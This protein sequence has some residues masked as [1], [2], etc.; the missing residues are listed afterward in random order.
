[1]KKKAL[2]EKIQ[3][4]E[5]KVQTLSE[6]KGIDWGKWGAIVAV[7]LFILTCAFGYY[8]YDKQKK[9]AEVVRA[10]DNKQ[11]EAERVEK[12]KSDLQRLSYDIT[13]FINALRQ[14]HINLKVVPPAT[15]APITEK[16]AYI[17]NSQASV[18]ANRLRMI[19][20]QLLSLN[21]KSKFLDYQLN[22]KLHS[23]IEY[24]TH[25]DFRVVHYNQLTTILEKVAVL[26]DKRKYLVRD[27]A[28]K[29][30]VSGFP[31]DQQQ[32]S[33]L[34]GFYAFEGMKFLK[35]RGVA[36][37]KTVS[38]DGDEKPQVNG[39]GYVLPAMIQ[40]IDEEDPNGD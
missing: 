23:N 36:N 35:V 33:Y 12:E 10:A 24:N 34:K 9:D 20:N 13:A 37:S 21:D 15:D 30:L 32:Y 31:L 3:Q 38:S 16:L 19:T 22:Y 28:V 7:V 1:M 17:K 27:Q 2:W 14:K 5:E 26:K 6:G 29:R 39:S 18:H 25:A 8:I 40:I 11:K 4:L